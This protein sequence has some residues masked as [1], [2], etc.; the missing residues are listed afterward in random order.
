MKVGDLIKFDWKKWDSWVWCECCHKALY[1]SDL[2]AT[3]LLISRKSHT[4]HNS[5]TFFTNGH[6]VVFG[7][8]SIETFIIC[9]SSV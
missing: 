4:F 7:T 5:V 3:W 2:G 9:K 1:E 8:H 6:F